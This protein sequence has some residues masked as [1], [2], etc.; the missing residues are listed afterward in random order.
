TPSEAVEKYGVKLTAEQ[1][2]I[3]DMC[4]RV[5]WSKNVPNRACQRN[6]ECGDGFCD[7]GKCI[8]IFSCGIALGSPCEK[9][10]QCPFQ[11]CIDGHCSSC[12]SDEECQ[13]RLGH[14]DR[15]CTVTQRHAP[16][17]ECTLLDGRP[18]GMDWQAIC[19]QRT[20][21]PKC[22]DGGP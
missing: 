11:M 8:A 3:A 22:Q 4:P 13:Q 17:R 20:D 18:A 6:D 10:G 15:K 2:V 12:I 19:A 14:P 1:K 5:P 9:D 7:R 16:G 21:H